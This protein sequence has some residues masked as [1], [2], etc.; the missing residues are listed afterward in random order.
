MCGGKGH[1]A[2]ICDNVV[3]VFA[4]QASD[5][6]VFSGKEEEAFVCDSPGKLSDAPVPIREGQNTGGC[7]ALNW[8][9]GDL[10]VIYNNGA[11]RHI[12]YSSAGI[13]NYRGE[14]RSRKQLAVLGT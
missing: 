12:T 5:D 7:S 2:E 10:V 1:T 8:H 4:C 13:I 9:V 6:E 11:P 14:K 3:S